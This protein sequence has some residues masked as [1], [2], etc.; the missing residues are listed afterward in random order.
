MLLGM[1]NTEAKLAAKAIKAGLI[2]CSAERAGAGETAA[3]AARLA[4]R[5]A[6]RAGMTTDALLDALRPS[7]TDDMV[8]WHIAVD[9]WHAACEFARL[10]FAS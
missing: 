5:L 2:A 7:V 4:G 6:F 10:S 8:S 9:S 1:G 3:D